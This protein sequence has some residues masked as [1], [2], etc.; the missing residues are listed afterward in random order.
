MANKE[1][2]PISTEEFKT[3]LEGKEFNIIDINSRLSSIS[4]INQGYLAM[5][6]DYNYQIEFYELTDEESAKTFY[7]NNKNKF[8]TL[9]GDL[10]AYTS[11]DGK[12]WAKYALSTDGKYMVVSRIAN[13]VIYLS[14]K[15]Q[16][17]DTVKDILKEIGY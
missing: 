3:A 2:Q 8:E 11:V 17:S 1:K 9:K 12:N 7:D 15:D 4:Q 10:S 6:S 14:V 13:T 5:E 16:Y